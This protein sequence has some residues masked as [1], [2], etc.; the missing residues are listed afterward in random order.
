[1]VDIFN[2]AIEL[3]GKG[4]YIG[5]S[6]MGLGV[7][8]Y[9]FKKLARSRT[10]IASNCKY[11]IVSPV[12]GRITASGI[13]VAGNRI[14]NHIRITRSLLSN[15]VQFMPINGSVHESKPL[16]INAP[17]IYMP[18]TLRSGVSIRSRVGKTFILQ[19]LFWHK[20]TTDN[21]T[22]EPKVGTNVTNE[23]T[24]GSA[25]GV[26][27]FSVNIDILL[28]AHISIIAEVGDM[29]TGGVTPIAVTSRDYDTVVS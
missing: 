24:C 18:Q 10:P 16:K 15:P 19:N 9:Y 6:I 27:P 1:M 4:I 23:I 28:P 20:L 8:F 21:T 12:D 29:V 22:R 5:A 3:V 25:F 14:Y 26:F 2:S 11:T 13:C 7:L 17:Q